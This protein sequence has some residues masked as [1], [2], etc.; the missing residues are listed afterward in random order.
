MATPDEA[1]KGSVIFT[2]GSKSCT[3]G[4]EDTSATRRGSFKGAL[5]TVPIPV[6]T[7]AHLASSNP[8]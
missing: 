7:K 6:A 1:P 5:P 2:V 3:L 4:A 8:G